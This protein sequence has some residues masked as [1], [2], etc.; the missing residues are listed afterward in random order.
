[1]SAFL[2]AHGGIIPVILLVVGVL[3]IVLSAIQQVLTKLSVAS[4]G[5]MTTVSN[6]VLKI[7]QWASANTPSPQK[8]VETVA[9]GTAAPPSE[10]KAP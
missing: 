8:T 7:V 5:W 6:I 9:A 1:M 10:V 2:Q 4:P 3:N